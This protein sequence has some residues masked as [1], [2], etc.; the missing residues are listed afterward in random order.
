[1]IYLIASLI[2][3]GLVALLLSVKLLTKRDAR[4]PS[5]HVSQ[6][7]PLRD[8]GIACHTSQHRDAQQK[9]SLKERLALREQ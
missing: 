3:L 2:A 9:L 6:Q 7:K 1:M 8:K 4:F 5:S